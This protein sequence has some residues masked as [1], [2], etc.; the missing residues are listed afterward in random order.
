M[1][2]QIEQTTTQPTTIKGGV[3]TM[4][5][6]FWENGRNCLPTQ[7]AIKLG[8]KRTKWRN[9]NL[10]IS[11]SEKIQLPIRYGKK[12]ST[13]KNT[14]TMVFSSLALDKESHGLIIPYKEEIDFSNYLNFERQAQK[15]ADVEGISKGDN[16][17][18][19]HWGCIGIYINSGSA[20]VKVDILNSYWKSLRLTDGEYAKLDPEKIRFYELEKDGDFSLLDKNYCLIPKVEINTRLDFLFFLYMKAEH[21]NKEKQKRYPTPQE[22]A[23]EINRSG[24]ETYYKENVKSEIT[25]FEDN[26]INGFLI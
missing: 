19:K 23:E 21:R 13:R 15:L 11:N 18:R 1:T 10:V 12:S 24:Y 3:I 17:L 20:K 7:K 6:L 25:T 22:I 9:E 5:S 14:Y 26:D 8:G 2:E 16:R 4:G